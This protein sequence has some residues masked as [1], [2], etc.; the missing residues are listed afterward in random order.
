M[1]Q[2]AMHSELKIFAGHAEEWNLWLDSIGEA[3][4]YQY[5]PFINAR[6]RRFQILSGNTAVAGGV[7]V[8][9]PVLGWPRRILAVHRGPV[10][11]MLPALNTLEIWARTEGAWCL[12][13]MPDILFTDALEAN[14]LSRNWQPVSPVRH[15]LRLD[16]APDEEVL[17]AGIE[18]RGRYQVNRADREGITVRPAQ[19]D[20]DVS[21]FCKLYA[22]M[23]VEKELVGTSEEFLFRL[24]KYLLAH[25]TRGVILLAENQGEILGANLLWRSASRVENIYGASCKQKIAVGYPLQWASILWA[26][27]VGAREYDFGGFD[28]SQNGGPALMKRAF[29]RNIVTLSPRWRKLYKPT[30][31]HTAQRL[32]SWIKS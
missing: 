23:I 25:P 32:R 6:D 28:P 11:D 31:F 10:G 29:C 15:T 24:G 7:A 22:N 2:L 5:E 4:A 18:S 13:I 17:L 9:A 20:H 26:K 8:S 14:F 16:L 30:L 12:E 21:V 3:S 19:N 1:L 27:A